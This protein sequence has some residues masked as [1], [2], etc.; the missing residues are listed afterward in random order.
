[1]KGWT[2]S[3]RVVG[4]QFHMQVEEFFG[5]ELRKGLKVT[6]QGVQLYLTSSTGTTLLFRKKRG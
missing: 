5:A 1:M 2:R 4:P 3:T 6:K